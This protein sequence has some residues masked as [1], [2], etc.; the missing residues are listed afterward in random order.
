QTQ[1]IPVWTGDVSS[2]KR[3]SNYLLSAGYFVPSIRPPTVS[4]GEG[5]VRLSITYHVGRR[6]CDDLKEAFSSY[7]STKEE[8]KEKIGQTI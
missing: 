1:I 7:L 8:A 2:T 3:L 4:E 5:R 6:G